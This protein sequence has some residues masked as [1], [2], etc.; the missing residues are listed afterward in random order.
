LG[1]GS[2]DLIILA[3]GVDSVRG[4]GIIDNRAGVVVHR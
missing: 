4:L 2:Y 1:L 3:T